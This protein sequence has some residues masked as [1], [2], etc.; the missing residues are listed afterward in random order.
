MRGN[1]KLCQAGRQQKF[2]HY[3]MSSIVKKKYFGKIE[4]EDDQL[5]VQNFL[6]Y[7]LSIL[8]AYLFIYEKYFTDNLGFSSNF[9]NNLILDHIYPV[10]QHVKLTLIGF[11]CSCSSFG[12]SC[13]KILMLQF[14]K[15]N[16]SAK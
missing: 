4:F 5:Q 2:L 15:R 6:R 16:Y 8:C 14:L 11:S 13:S 10:I 7:I 9:Q 12:F 1:R 3:T